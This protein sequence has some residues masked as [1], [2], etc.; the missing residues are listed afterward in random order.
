VPDAGEDASAVALFPEH[1]SQTLPLGTKVRP[2]LPCRASPKPQSHAAA[3]RCVCRRCPLAAA[4][5][6]PARAAPR[7]WM[8][9]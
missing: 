1:A 5:A 6:P 9:D 8:R 2:A 3:P 7:Q 4:D